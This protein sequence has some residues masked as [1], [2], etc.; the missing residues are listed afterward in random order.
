MLLPFIYSGDVFLL[1]LETVAEVDF[2]TVPSTLYSQYYIIGVSYVINTS[3]GQFNLL[4]YLLKFLYF[5][6]AVGNSFSSYVLEI[7]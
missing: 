5:K 6:A 7:S 1:I 3:N 4:T 2:E